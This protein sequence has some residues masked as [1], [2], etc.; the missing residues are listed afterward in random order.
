[1]ESWPSLIAATRKGLLELDPAAP[2]LFQRGH[3]LAEP[4][5][6]FCEDPATGAWLAALS[7]GHFGVKL[8]RSDDRGDTWR[9]L[10]PPAFAKVEGDDGP[11]VRMIWTLEADGKGRLWAGTLPGAL[12]RSEDGGE[13]WSLVESLW[14]V[15]ERADWFGG[16]YD[17]PGIHSILIDP[18]DRDRLTVGV[19]C[20][21]VWRT[22]DAGASWRLGGEGLRA[23]YMPPGMVDARHIQD[24]H[25]LATNDRDPEV[26]WCQ[27]HNGIFRSE[28]GGDTFHEIETV[29]PSFGFAV[30]VDPEDA[31]IAW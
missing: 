4:V 28:D 18:R 25:R 8:H 2:R 13:T 19:S 21:G 30:A 9:E 24:P 16:G 31:D 3:F 15:P 23:A 7:L 27:H 5:T 17:H 12:F 26:V 11:S 6:A 29:E 14:N 20:G 22:E 10:T 1:M